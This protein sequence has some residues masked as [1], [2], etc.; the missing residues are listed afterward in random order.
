MDALRE[1]FGGLQQ[2]E[3]WLVTIAAGVV[4]TTVLFLL[5]EPL[6]KATENAE[7]RIDQKTSELGAMQRARG[8]IQ[9][10]AA[11]SGNSVSPSGTPLVVVIDR[12]STSARLAPYLKR[13]QPDGDN[14]IRVTFEAAPFNALI[15]FLVDLQTSHGLVLSN[16]TVNKADAPGTVNA[17]LT[18]VRAGV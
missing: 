10:L 2:R 5:V 17:S 9:S 18:L 3:R 14:A 11:I 7:A 15:D 13:N 4:L 6:F 8:E 1:W 16:A 12:S